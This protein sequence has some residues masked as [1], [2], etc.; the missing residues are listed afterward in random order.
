MESRQTAKVI[1][2]EFL[3]LVTCYVRPHV[4]AKPKKIGNLQKM[5]LMNY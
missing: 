1:F 4:A 5:Q 3:W 2:V